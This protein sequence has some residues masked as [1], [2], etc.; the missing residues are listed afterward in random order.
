MES[1]AKTQGNGQPAGLQLLEESSLHAWQGWCDLLL[2]GGIHQAFPQ[3][4]SA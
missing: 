4:T 3:V 1:F 2:L